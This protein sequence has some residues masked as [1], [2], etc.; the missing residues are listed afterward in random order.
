MAFMSLVIMTTA[1]VAEDWQ[2]SIGGHLSAEY[3]TDELKIFRG[4]VHADNV[5]FTLRPRL[6]AKNG[7]WTFVAEGDWAKVAVDDSQF[8]KLFY[9]QYSGSDFRIQAGK[10]FTSSV[11]MAPAARYLETVR[12]QSFPLNPAGWGVK[13]E[14]DFG[15]FSWSYDIVT[16]RENGWDDISGL[17]TNTSLQWEIN[18]CWKVR[19]YAGVDLEDED[20]FFGAHAEYSNGPVTFRVAGYDVDGQYGGYLF[21]GYRLADWVE[22]HG[23]VDGK[24]DKG[25]NQ[26]VGF[27]F[28]LTEKTEFKTDYIHYGGDREENDVFAFQLL[29]RF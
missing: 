21:A 2:V 11:W 18:E 6:I 13:F 14:K 19:A 25:F 10:L 22:I 7:P 9:L 16:G 1:A 23:G 28:F 15:D 5:H 26:V 8:L 29:R 24:E 17:E 3:A 12:F 27:R 4:E 20:T